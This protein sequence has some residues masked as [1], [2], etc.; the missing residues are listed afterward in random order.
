MAEI[1]LFLC[2]DVMTGRGIDQILPHPCGLAIHEFRM[3][4]DLG[5]VEIAEAANGPMKKT[6][7]S[8]AKIRDHS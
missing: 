1:K 8:P 6:L 7:S 5:Y 4:S 3:D 2:E